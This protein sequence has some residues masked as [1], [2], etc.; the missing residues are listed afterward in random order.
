MFVLSSRLKEDGAEVI[1]LGLCVVLLMKDR[2][3]PW[4]VLVPRRDGV[5]E[6]HE[7]AKADRAV[8]MEEIC[9]ASSVI[10]TLFK[11]DKINIGALGN[12]VPQL[13]V[14]VIGRFKTDR[15]W[16]GP[17]WGTGAMQP[18]PPEE[19]DKTILTLRSAFKTLA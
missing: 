6:M 7:L 1:G 16:P 9:A 17:V 2:S 14:H 4:L 18:Y 19:L 11:P 13:H 10:G 8:L 12:L 15:A 3:F 5:R